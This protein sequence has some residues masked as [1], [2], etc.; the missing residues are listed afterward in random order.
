[1][2]RLEKKHIS[3]PEERFQDFLDIIPNLCE[4]LI[5]GGEPL[6]QKRHY[7]MLEK[8]MPYA[9]GIRLSYNS[10]LTSLNLKK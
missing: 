10:N 8:M 7:I 3:L 9:K 2:G 1:M 5:A 6:Q 4:V